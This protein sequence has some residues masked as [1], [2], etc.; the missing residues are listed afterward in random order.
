V[1]CN[2]VLASCFGHLLSYV[3][4]MY[5]HLVL[6]IFCPSLHKFQFLHLFNYRLCDL[7]GYR[8][9]GKD[10]FLRFIHFGSSYFSAGATT[11]AVLRCQCFIWC[12]CTSKVCSAHCDVLLRGIKRLSLCS[13]T[14]H[15]ANRKHP[16]FR[17]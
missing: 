1:A 11:A 3:L 5:L 8:S 7:L 6:G 10:A 9:L 13:F 15:P 17:I 14:D 16:F 4:I 12:I 2:H